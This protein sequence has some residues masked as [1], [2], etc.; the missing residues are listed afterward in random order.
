[1]SFGQLPFLYDRLRAARYETV[2]AVVAD[3]ADVVEAE[4]CS[5]YLL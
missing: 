3:A 2:V 1:M 5:C 4:D